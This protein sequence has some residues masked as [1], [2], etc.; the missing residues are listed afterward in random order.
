MR[1]QIAATS[2]PVSTAIGERKPKRQYTKDELLSLSMWT[3]EHVAQFLGCSAETVKTW[4]RTN[5]NGPKFCRVT[6]RQVR[7]RPQD[8]QDFL[9]ANTFRST[10]ELPGA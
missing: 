1:K 5:S 2:P 9:A 10:S 6:P 4:R 8:V 3:T 7:Y